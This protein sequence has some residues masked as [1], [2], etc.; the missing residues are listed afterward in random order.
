MNIRLVLSSLVT[1]RALEEEHHE[2]PWQTIPTHTKL[3]KS[4]RRVYKCCQKEPRA[5][6]IVFTSRFLM[7]SLRLEVR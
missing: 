6:A 2:T 1:V 3:W 7:C 5:E 4:V